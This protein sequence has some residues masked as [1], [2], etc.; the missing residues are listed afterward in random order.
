MTNTMALGTA[1]ARYVHAITVLLPWF[2]SE[3]YMAPWEA[4]LNG[5]GG[6]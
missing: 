5:V 2:P 3:Y 1:V 4:R 6:L